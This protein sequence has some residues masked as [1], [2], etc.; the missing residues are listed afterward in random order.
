MERMGYAFGPVVL[1]AAGFGAPHGRHRSSSWPTPRKSDTNGA[2]LHGDG[3]MDAVQLAPWPS[4]VTN[5][6]KG[7]DY[8]Y[9]NGDHSRPCL[10]LP[11]AAKLATWA[12]AHHE[13]LAI[14]SGPEVGRGAVRH[15][16]APATPPG[17]AD[18]GHS[19][20]G[21]AGTQAATWGF[22]GDAEW[23]ACRDGKA[24]AVEPGSFPLAHGDSSRVVRLRAYG[25]AICAPVAEEFIVPTK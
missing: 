8:T 23:I 24:R 6:A 21:I 3:G 4:P 17:A 9:A 13:G 5:D 15:E 22:W 7:S 10:K 12:D 14:G 19:L 1:P 11:G 16:G 2:G 18:P 20:G 25:N